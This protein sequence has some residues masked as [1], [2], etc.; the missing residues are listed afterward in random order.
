[1]KNF[2]DLV[3]EAAKGLDNYALKVDDRLT[4]LYIND[5]ELQES[6]GNYD[7]E[8]MEKKIL[9]V[10][11]LKE[12]MGMTVFDAVYAQKGYGPITYKVAMTL[13]NGLAPVQDSRITKAAE[14]VWKE[15]YNG[16]GS[17]EVEIDSWGSS[18][19][20]MW[21]R[22]TYRLKKPLNL[23]KN[24]KAHDKFIG[25]DP[26]QEKIGMLDEL[27]DGILISKMGEIY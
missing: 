23:S 22:S 7:M 12:D 14:K 15:F 18:E 17:S 13:A 6:L 1:M 25:K 19:D 9:F 2:R 16:K 26:Y 27:A 10:F 5:S 4:Y 20:M 21:K 11:G 24:H 8:G 3:L